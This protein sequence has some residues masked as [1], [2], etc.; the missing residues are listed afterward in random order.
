MQGSRACTCSFA[1]GLRV[2]ASCLDCH[3]SSQIWLASFKSSCSC[4]CQI[5][6]KRNTNACTSDMELHV[7][8]PNS[9]MRLVVN[10]LDLLRRPEALCNLELVPCEAGA[11]RP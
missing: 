3:Q 7:Q 4:L 6:N 1:A 5:W 9:G 11:C 10:R 2:Q 8:L